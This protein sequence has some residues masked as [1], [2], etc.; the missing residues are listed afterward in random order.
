[1]ASNT[2]HVPHDRPS[3]GHG[4]YDARNICHVQDCQHGGGDVEL[5]HVQPS[6]PV[7]VRP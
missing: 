2:L 6:A 1:M 4:A 3:P 7:P 5:Q